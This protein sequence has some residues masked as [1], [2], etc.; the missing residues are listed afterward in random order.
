[1]DGEFAGRAVLVT[2]AGRGMGRGIAEAFARAGASVMIGA[3]TMS[4]AEEAR[5]A[6]RAGGGTAEIHSVDVKQRAECENLVAATVKAFGRLDVIVHSA[7]EIPHG[8]IGQ[9][10]D[11]ALEAGFASIV[12]APWWLIEAARPHLRASGAGRLVVIGSVNGTSA[13]VPNMPAYGM[14]KA[15]LEAFVRAVA[16]EVAGEGITVNSVNPGLVASAN[17]LE[18]LG[19]DGLA[20]YGATLPVGRGGTTGDIARACLFLA[21]PDAGYITGA[22]LRIDGGS[23]LA[24]P[25]AGGQAMLQER[26]KTRTGH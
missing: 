1:M 14:A 25:S 26:L 6:I 21:S 23:S 13:V 22:S 11:E 17:A 19:E 16:V 18:V 5:D 9:V 24:P 8:G 10:S 4:Y 15:A 3:R 20:A 12:K 2:G 7:A